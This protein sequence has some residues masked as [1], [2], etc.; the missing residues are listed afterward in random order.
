MII[1][2]T[3]LLLW[4]RYIQSLY[5]Q[6]CLV[7]YTLYTVLHKC[8]HFI[9]VAYATIYI[10]PYMLLLLLWICDRKYVQGL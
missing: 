7:G 3:S 4:L 9:G 6:I 2:T 1:V 5:N 10:M 8:V